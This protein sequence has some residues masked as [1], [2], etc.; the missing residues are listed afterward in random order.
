[1]IDADSQHSTSPA[2]PSTTSFWRAA[3]VAVLIFLSPVL[4]EL[5]AGIVTISRLWL[6]IPEMAVYGGAALMI[7]EVAR[8]QGRVVDGGRGITERKVAVGGRA[9]P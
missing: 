2:T 6:L 8:R 4:T 9:S 3:P 5:L 1:M 7:R